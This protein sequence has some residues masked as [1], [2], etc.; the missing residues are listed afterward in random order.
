MNQSVLVGHRR[1]PDRGM[2]SRN[3]LER[4]KIFGH[5]VPILAEAESAAV[6]WEHSSFPAGGARN[7]EYRNLARDLAVELEAMLDCHAQ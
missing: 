1:F 2:P 7:A 3:S 6:R 5:S 4:T